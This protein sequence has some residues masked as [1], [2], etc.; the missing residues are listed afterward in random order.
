MKLEFTGNDDFNKAIADL[1][2]HTPSQQHFIKKAMR[3][4]EALWH[5]DEWEVE[6]FM[7]DDDC[8]GH[9]VRFSKLININD[10]KDYAGD[11]YDPREDDGYA[12]EFPYDGSFDNLPYDYIL[13]SCVMRNFDPTN[14]GH[15]TVHFEQNSVKGGE[16]YGLFND[17]IEPCEPKNESDLWNFLDNY[18]EANLSE[19]HEIGMFDPTCKIY[20]YNQPNVVFDEC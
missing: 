11:S 19:I 16:Y 13:M 18:V 3:V 1:P 15:D 2:Y 17:D 10:I 12:D 9:L 14:G 6:D 8:E 5:G 4:R 20:F 7:L